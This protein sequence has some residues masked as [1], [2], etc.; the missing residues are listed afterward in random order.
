MGDLENLSQLPVLEVFEVTQT[1]LLSRNI[2]NGFLDL[3]NMNTEKISKIHKT[4]SSVPPVPE[5]DLD[6]QGHRNMVVQ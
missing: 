3:E 5:V 6:F 4:E 1:R 2:S